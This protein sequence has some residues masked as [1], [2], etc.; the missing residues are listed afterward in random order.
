MLLDLKHPEAYDG[1][2]V[3]CYSVHPLVQRL[4]APAVTGIF[5][6]SVLTA[7]S[8]SLETQ[9]FGIVS[10]GKVWE[11]ALTEAVNGFLGSKAKGDR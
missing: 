3:A 4:Q 5:E 9:S 6:A 8:V 1:V 10:T 7:L 11:T 2:L